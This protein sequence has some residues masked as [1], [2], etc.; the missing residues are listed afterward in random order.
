MNVKSGRQGFLVD[1][2][3]FR[4]HFGLNHFGLNEDPPRLPRWKVAPVGRFPLSVRTGESLG[5]PLFG[6]YRACS[7]VQ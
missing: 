7:A 3:Y 6:V 5:A 1:A 4:E 2:A